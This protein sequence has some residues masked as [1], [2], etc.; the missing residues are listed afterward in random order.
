MPWQGVT[1]SVTCSSSVAQNIAQVKPDFK[2]VLTG[3]MAGF[4]A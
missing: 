1:P 4:A 3:Y 2:D